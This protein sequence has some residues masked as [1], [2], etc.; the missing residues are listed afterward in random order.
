MSFQYQALDSIIVSNWT[1][2]F[3]GY[4]QC[5]HIPQTDKYWKLGK[6]PVSL[7]PTTY[8]TPTSN[9]NEYEFC[10]ATQYTNTTFRQQEL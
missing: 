10:Y 3:G 5:R 1:A 6:V 7:K 4:K 8:R 2:R 9:L